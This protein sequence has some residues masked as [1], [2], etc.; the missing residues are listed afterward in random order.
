MSISF[1]DN[2]LIIQDEAEF[3]K[4]IIDSV[5]ASIH[6]MKVNKEGNTL[7]VWMNKQYSKILGYSFED[8]QKIGIDYKNDQLYH[9]DDIEI[10]RNAIK[11]A[12]KGK[13]KNITGMFRAKT[14]QGDWKW[15]LS[16]ARV[17]ELNG[18]EFLLSVMVD[19]SENMADYNILVERY[20][21]EI[22]ALKNQ[23][24]IQKLTKT[25]KRIIREL[26]SGKTTK[27][28]AEFK[29]RSYETINN[30]KRNIF[31]KLGF[32]KISELVCFAVENGLN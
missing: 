20:S 15:I 18:E 1:K 12:F 17:I 14:T 31:Q 13:K 28:I 32:C 22:A 7:P 11:S 6:L 4:K 3:Y 25:E 16:S 10:I 26:V 30:H 21:K 27:Q 8:R 2:K 24:L 23:L 5:G 19:I 9:P 29:A